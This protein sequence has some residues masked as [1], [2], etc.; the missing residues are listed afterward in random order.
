LLLGY[1]AITTRQLYLVYPSLRSTEFSGYV[2]DDWRATRW[3]TLNIG[4]RYEVFTPLGEIHKFASN[5]DLGSGKIIV[6]GQNGVG[7]PRAS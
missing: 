4:L 5:V 6:A 3:L 7:L 2:Q 1:P